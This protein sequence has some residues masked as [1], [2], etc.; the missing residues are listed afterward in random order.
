[1]KKILLLFVLFVGTQFTFAQDAAFKADV[2]KLLK[3][4]GSD[5]TVAVAK[6]QLVG[7]VPQT[8]QSDFL[9]DFDAAMPSFYDKLAAI[10]MKEYTHADVKA[11]LSFYDTPA[12]KKMSEK[13]GPIFEQSMAVGQEWG[14]QL[15]PLLMKYMQ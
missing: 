11:I 10:Y 6:K 9:K 15:Q 8:K 12:G 5:A 2:M 13:A 4:S 1:M 3:A 14:Q 7:M